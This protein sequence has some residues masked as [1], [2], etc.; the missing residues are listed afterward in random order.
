V[1]TPD[2]RA[3]RFAEAAP[4]ERADY[5]VQY[6]FAE[7]APQAIAT[8]AGLGKALHAAGRKPPSKQAILGSSGYDVV[9]MRANP[10]GPLGA[11]ALPWYPATGIF[12]TVESTTAADPDALARLVDVEG[13]AGAW[14][15][16]GAGRD[17]SPVKTNPQQSATVFY[18][19]DDPVVVAER[20][21]G[22][23]ERD[24][25]RSGAL[26]LLAA[27]FYVVRPL[28]LGLRLP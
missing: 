12:L 14:R 10:R 21:K 18:L 24:W 13:V 28:D 11:Y 4:Y 8:F 23:V 5:V 9:D 15:Y 20:L 27:P 6:L 2:C 26:G 1:S 22:V 25:S 3:A 16:V 19:Y 7:P 17:L